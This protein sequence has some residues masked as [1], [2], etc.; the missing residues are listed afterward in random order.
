M[1][2]SPR[3]NDIFDPVFF[4]ATRYGLVSSLLKKCLGT[5]KVINNYIFEQTYFSSRIF[6]ESLSHL[7]G[8]R[9][10]VEFSDRMLADETPSNSSSKS[11]K[12]CLSRGTVRVPCRDTPL[13]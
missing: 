5:I 1:N 6:P 7:P 3:W 8:E 12:V 10:V 4:C 13:V 2:C 9:E 11:L